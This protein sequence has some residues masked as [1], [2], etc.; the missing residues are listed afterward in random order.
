MDKH[1][2]VFAT[3]NAHKAREI[4]QLVGDRYLIQT[5]T[6]IGC[7]EEIAETGKTLEE[8][9]RIKSQYVY[10]KYGLNCFADDTGL[11]VAALDGAPGVFSARYAGDRRSDADNINLLLKNLAGKASRNAQFRTAISLMLDGRE[12][13]FEGILKGEITQELKGENG[14]GYDPIFKPEGYVFTLAQLSLSE[15]NKISHRALA[16]QQLLLFL[17]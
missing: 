16:M 5:L 1:I 9:A 6:D 7:T 11:E 15:K 12:T 4:Q 10:E 8:N 13:L 2:L 3:H 17:K 14:F